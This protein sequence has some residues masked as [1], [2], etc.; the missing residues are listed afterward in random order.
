LA[1]GLTDCKKHA[2]L[3]K[4]GGYIMSND[5]KILCILEEMQGDIKSLKNDVASLRIDTGNMKIDIAELKTDMSVLREDIET[6]K[7][8]D[9]EFRANLNT[10]LEWADDVGRIEQIP[11]IKHN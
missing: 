4:Q 3:G 7:E 8:N 2:I 10:I 9:E 5:E 1:G 6:L 11:L